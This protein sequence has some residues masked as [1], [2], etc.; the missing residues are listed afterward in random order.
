[1]QFCPKCKAI[2]V[3]SNDPKRKSV[4]CKA[5]NT[6]IRQKPKIMIK[7]KI[8]L[9][10][11]DKIEVVDKKIET[12]PKTDEECPKCGHNKAYYWTVQTRAGDEAETRFF[13]CTKCKHRWRSYS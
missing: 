11:D 3:P 5:C 2:L 12:L 8:E 7:E 4:R 1:M 13:E 6:L 9:R 10:K